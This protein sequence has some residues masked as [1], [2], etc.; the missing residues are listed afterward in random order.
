MK[1]ITRYTYLNLETRP[2]R[3]LLAECTARR[4]GIPDDLVH[5]WTG[6]WF[7]T[8]DEIGRYAVEEHGFKNFKPCIGQDKPIAGTSIGH[9]YN[10]VSHLIDRVTRPDTLEL[11]L[12]DDVC[13]EPALI[14]RGHAYL[15]SLCR[16]LQQYGELNMLL[17]NPFYLG[18]VMATHF[19]DPP[20]FRP[21]GVYIGD[22]VYEGI[23]GGCDFAMVFSTKGAEYLRDI[24]LNNPPWRPI[25]VFLN[26]EKWDLPGIFTTVFPYV[27][28]YANHIVGSNTI[29]TIGGS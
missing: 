7:E 25:E 11:Y 5:F 2:D 24:M 19:K 10:L 29:N 26:K 28:R 22:S 3:R 9:M 27:R 1:D 13:F 12:H 4:D 21:N 23:R 8:W 14:G 16:T 18:P 17:L 15:N 6:K 20:I